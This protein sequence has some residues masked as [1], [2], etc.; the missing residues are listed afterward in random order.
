MRECEAKNE[1]HGAS[2]RWMTDIRIKSPRDKLMIWLDGKVEREKG[3][4][5]FETIPPYVGTEKDGQN[6]QQ[7]YG[8]RFDEKGR[9]R[10]NARRGGAD[11]GRKWRG[12]IDGRNRDDAVDIKQYLE[13]STKVGN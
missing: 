8:R 1:Q 5:S 3:T 7:K 6:T 12:R 13:D 10:R 4:K 9:S 11:K 2:V